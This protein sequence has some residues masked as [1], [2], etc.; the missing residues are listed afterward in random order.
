M[1]E[2]EKIKDTAE[3]NIDGTAG[4]SLSPVDRR[5]TGIMTGGLK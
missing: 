2:L 3:W 4:E 5:N 1:E